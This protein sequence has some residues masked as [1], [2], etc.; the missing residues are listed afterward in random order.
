MAGHKG[1]LLKVREGKYKGNM[2]GPRWNLQTQR[3]FFS[4]LGDLKIYTNLWK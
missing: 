1:S 2:M 3:A 4:F